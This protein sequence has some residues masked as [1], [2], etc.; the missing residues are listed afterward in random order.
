MNHTRL[1]A[2]LGTPVMAMAI[3]SSGSVALAQDAKTVSAAS[4]GNEIV[5]T[6]RKIEES[7]QDI[8]V[9]LPLGLITYQRSATA[10]V[11]VLH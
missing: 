6:A 3:M 2:L 4:T 5:V 8:L 1:N 11:S 10:A 7:N 9:A